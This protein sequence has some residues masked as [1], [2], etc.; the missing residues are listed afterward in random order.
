M[1]EHRSEP[2][3]QKLVDGYGNWFQGGLENKR[4][5]AARM[6]QELYPYTSIFSPIRIGRLTVKNRVVMAPMGNLM[7][8]EET[9]RPSEKMTAYFAARAK[10]GVGLLTSG[11]VPIS[12]GID[13]TV[14]A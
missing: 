2:A 14:S 8:C 4:G 7:M 13:P 6:T 3:I 5:S 10:G 12:H 9:G 1:S 11:L